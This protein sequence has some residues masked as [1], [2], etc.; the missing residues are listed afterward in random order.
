VKLL[1]RICYGLVLVAMAFSVA[2]VCLAYVNA[3]TN[4]TLVDAARYDVALECGQTLEELSR[5]GQDL[6]YYLANPNPIAHDNL[7]VE[8]QIFDG[9][10]DAFDLGSLKSYSES[11]PERA[12]LVRRYRQS[13]NTVQALARSVLGGTTPL[14]SGLIDGSHHLVEASHD[15]LARMC[16]DSQ[17]Y[18]SDSIEVTRQRLQRNNRVSLLLISGLVVSGLGLVIVLGLQNYLARTGFRMQTE[19]AA[20]YERLAKHDPL[21]GLPNRYEFMRRL[22]EAIGRVPNGHEI[23][24]I[25]LDLDRFKLVNDSLG[26]G[27]GDAL[28]QSVAS[29]LLLIAGAESDI[30]VARLGGDEF[31]VLVETPA[32]HKSRAGQFAQRIADLLKSPYDIEG[33]RVSACATLGVAIA[34]EHAMIATE[35]ARKSDTALYCGKSKERGTWRLYEPAMDQD[36]HLRRALEMELSGALERNEL[37]FHYQPIVE[38]ETGSTKGVEALL[39]WAHPVHGVVAPA[40]FIPI[41]EESGLIVRIGEVML[42]HACRD[43]LL[44]PEHWQIAVNLSAV[45]FQRGDIV[46]TVR[47]ALRD[48]GLAPERLELEITESVV[49]NNDGHTLAALQALKA[50]GVRIALDD[51]GTGYSSLS[52]LRRFGFH[53]LKIDRSFIQDI[54]SDRQAVQIVRSIASLAASLDMT[55]TVEGVEAREQCPVLMFAGCTHAQGYLFARPAPLHQLLQWSERTQPLIQAAMAS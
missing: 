53:K 14:S 12:D 36:L 30:L 54:P 45:Q 2:G 26:H 31:V 32:G 17:E 46:A 10:I 35:L 37:A 47:D 4:D 18:A 48:S 19:T 38:L 28:L 44:M 5:F 22:L 41:A 49:L 20:M 43:A 25:T 51:F 3:R 15:F 39:R 52:Y 1:D 7:A 40:T 55:I 42:H 29:R 13:A 8:V 24:V 9:R 11:A 50:L 21:T 16:T 34:P 27:A 23:A 6:G 33:Q